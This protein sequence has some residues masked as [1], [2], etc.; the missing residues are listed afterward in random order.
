MHQCTHSGV[1]CTGARYGTPMVTPRLRAVR[2]AVPWL[3]GGGGGRVDGEG[4]MAGGAVSKRDGLGRP[5]SVPSAP[6][7][8]CVW[9]RRP[10]VLT[11]VAPAGLLPVFTQQ[12]PVRQWLDTAPVRPLPRQCYGA[13]FIQW[14]PNH[15][16]SHYYSG[17]FWVVG[18]LR[19]D[20]N[21]FDLPSPQERLSQQRLKG[22]SLSVASM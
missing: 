6:P 4:V 17:V 22:V 13:T 15:N 8:G 19:L 11:G 14:V 5:V 1:Q 10:P 2:A 7:A 3:G 12:S 9:P 16:R 18:R 21:G 20:F